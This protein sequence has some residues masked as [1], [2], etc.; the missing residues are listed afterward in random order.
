MS[1]C[2]VF[3]GRRKPVG[4]DSAWA[5]RLF[6]PE[7][8]GC[9]MQRIQN[10]VH[11]GTACNCFR[12]RVRPRR[13]HAQAAAEC[14]ASRYW[15]QLHTVLHPTSTFARAGGI[16]FAGKCFASSWWMRLH[17]GSC[18]T[19]T[20]ARAGCCRV[21]CIRSRIRPLRPQLRAV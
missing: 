17:P 15:V 5:A 18:P 11:P 4:L 13:S 6:E 19:P 21:H 10:G 1:A 9:R 16:L 3:S 7:C 12:A 8:R 14:T 20:L 2:L